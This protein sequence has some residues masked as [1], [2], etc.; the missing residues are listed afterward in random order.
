MARPYTAQEKEYHSS[1]VFARVSP[2]D[3]FPEEKS[4]ETVHQGVVA[5]T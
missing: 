5:E 2:L 4:L 1:T 3:L